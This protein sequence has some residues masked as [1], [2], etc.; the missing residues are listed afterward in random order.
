L[1]A[2]ALQ[3]LQEGLRSSEACTWRRCQLLLARARGQTARVIAEPLGCDDQ[4]VRHAIYAFNTIG[5]TALPRRSSA[6]Q[7]PPPYRLP[8]RPTRA[9]ART[10]ASEPYWF[11]TV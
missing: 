3:T 1:T 10:V 9:V 2:D 11:R 4:T 6:P 5:L 8:Q 7:R